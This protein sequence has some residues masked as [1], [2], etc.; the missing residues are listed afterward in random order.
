MGTFEYLGTI[1]TLRRFQVIRIARPSLVMALLMLIGGVFLF[2]G[3]IAN[4][5]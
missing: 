2:F 4:L 5:F 3:I 1:K